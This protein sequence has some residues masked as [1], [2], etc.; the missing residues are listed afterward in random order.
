MTEPTLLIVG[1][2]RGLGLG[3]ASEFLARGWRVI[4]TVRS[5]SRTPLHD[6]AET[7]AG[8]LIVE[9]LDINS[10]DETDALLERLVSQTLDMLF[11][12]AGTTNEEPDTPVGDVSVDV[13]QHVMLTNTF[14]PMR[15]IEALQHLVPASGLIGV[16]S[17]GQGSIANNEVGLREVY[18]CSKAALNMAM[19]SFAAREKD[20]SRALLTLA[21]GWIRTDLGGADAPYTLEDSLPILADII[22]GKRQRPGLEY[23]DRF[24]KV[25]PW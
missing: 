5:G 20:A 17:S 24:G 12:N 11:V 4:G 14:A 22:E 13:F 23:L 8:R 6:L 7:C 25:V 18:R 2:S 19:R 3:L 15:V 1:A 16:M 21:P 9:T 10:A